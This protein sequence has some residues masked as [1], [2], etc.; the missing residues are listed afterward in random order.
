M[1]STTNPAALTEC[2]VPLD[3]EGRRAVRRYWERVIREEWVPPVERVAGPGS[4][5]EL[6]ER[7]S[8][9]QARRAMARIAA[10]SRVHPLTTPP[11]SVPSPVAGEAA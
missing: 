3:E 2:V 7:R 9:R 6:D 4:L 8:R 1:E 11:L 10:A 5:A